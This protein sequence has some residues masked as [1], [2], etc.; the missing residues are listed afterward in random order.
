MEAAWSLDYCL[1]CD[2]ETKEGA[3]CSQR[4]R[5]Q[6]VASGTSSP[7]PTSPTTEKSST[8]AATTGTD[9][10]PQST[11]FYLAP[12]FDFAAHRPRGPSLP[13]I[14]DVSSQKLAS[15]NRTQPSLLQQQAH[16]PTSPRALSSSSSRSS[17][18][19]I[20]SSSSFGDVADQ[21]R[22]ELL[23]YTN[24]FDQVRDW[25]RRRTTTSN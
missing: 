14:Y 1:G 23:I 8:L 9:A 22:N 11:G 7:E 12:A 20:G 10:R 25:R 21:H 13:N 24:S 17:L 4:C 3:Y 18:S 16:A 15:V 5:L 2:R 6:D 19:S